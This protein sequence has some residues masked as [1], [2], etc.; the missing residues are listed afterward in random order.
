MSRLRHRLTSIVIQ[1]Q[2]KALRRSCVC[3]FGDA[4]AALPA[5]QMLGSNGGV[6]QC[7]Q[8]ESD[9]IY[10]MVHGTGYQT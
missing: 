1:E 5:L 7:Q 10:V 9:S 4:G 3:G 6:S 2:S 8:A